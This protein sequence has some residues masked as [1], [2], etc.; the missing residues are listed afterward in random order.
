M[1][2]GSALHARIGQSLFFPGL[3]GQLF[4][5]GLLIRRGEMIGCIVLLDLFDHRLAIGFSALEQILRS[6]G[7]QVGVFRDGFLPLRGADL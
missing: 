5:N 1:G 4:L 2:T 6:L 3:A 7:E